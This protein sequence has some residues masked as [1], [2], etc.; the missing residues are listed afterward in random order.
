MFIWFISCCSV[1][2]SKRKAKC[3]WTQ[4][5]LFLIFK[6][7]FRSRWNIRLTRECGLFMFQRQFKLNF[8]FPLRLF[9]IM[10]FFSMY[11]YSSKAQW[12]FIE[13]QWHRGKSMKS[14]LKRILCRLALVVILDVILVVKEKHYLYKTL[15]LLLLCIISNLLFTTVQWVQYVTRTVCTTYATIWAFHGLYFSNLFLKFPR[16]FIRCIIWM[17]CWANSSVTPEHWM[18]ISYTK[19]YQWNFSFRAPTMGRSRYFFSYFYVFP[20]F[21]SY[22]GV[23]ITG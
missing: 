11:W 10:F 5:Y 17:K 7:H 8:R 6:F 20:V 18:M 13:K 19:R 4:L 3:P 15:L 16:N 14:C 22:L 1:N 9:S 21:V 12:T 2:N 23:W